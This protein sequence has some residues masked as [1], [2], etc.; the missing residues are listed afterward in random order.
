MNVKRMRQNKNRLRFLALAVVLVGGLTSCISF[1]DGKGNLIEAIRETQVVGNGVMVSKTIPLPD[2]TTLEVER[3]VE[4]RYVATQTQQLSVSTHENLM[5][6]VVVTCQLG[7]LKITIDSALYRVGDIDVVV[8]LPMNPKL[9]RINASSAAEV[10]FQEPL[11]LI[12]DLE[13]E[14]RSSAEING[15]IQAK[16]VVMSTSSSAEMELD[17]LVDALKAHISSSASVELS[18]ACREAELMVTSAAELD[19]EQL[20]ITECRAHASSAGE[21]DLWCTG[22]LQAEASSAGEIVYCGPCSVVKQQ[23][24]AGEVRYKEK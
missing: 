15:K 11:V 23:S 9:A 22:R 17:L 20:Q 16:R 7:H 10:N 19:A 8:T 13:L 24:S 4:V 6:Y 18:G 3:G 14:A 21:I 1:L 5:P 2:Y 12:H